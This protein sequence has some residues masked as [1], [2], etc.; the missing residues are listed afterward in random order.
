MLA[1]ALARPIGS[2]AARIQ[3]TPDLLPQDTTARPPW[4]ALPWG[5]RRVG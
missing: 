4:V 5:G 2:E 1:R 3:S